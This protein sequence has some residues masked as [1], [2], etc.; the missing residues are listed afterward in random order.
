MKKAAISLRIMSQLYFPCVLS[1]H[2]GYLT[3]SC[4]VITEV[5]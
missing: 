2:T 4:T 3:K 1:T 5:S